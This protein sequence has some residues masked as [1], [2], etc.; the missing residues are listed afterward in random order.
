M[1]TIIFGENAVQILNT[2]AGI[3]GVAVRLELLYS[4]ALFLR[5]RT[6]DKALQTTVCLVKKG[7]CISCNAQ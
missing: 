5:D 7:S 2:E 6:K 1:G 3:L 4:S